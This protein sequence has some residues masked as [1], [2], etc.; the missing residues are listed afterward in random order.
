MT[1]RHAPASSRSPPGRWTGTTPAYL[2]WHL[3]DHLPEQYS[4]VRDPPRHEVARRRRVR[5]A[6]PGGRGRAR[7]GRGTPSA[8]SSPSRSRTR[9]PR[10]GGSAAG[11]PRRAATPSRPP[12]TCSAP[13][14]CVDAQRRA[15]PRSCRPPPSRSGR[16]AACTCSS[17]EP[18]DPRTRSRP[19]G[20]GTATEHLPALLAVEGVAGRLRVP[21]HARRSAR[22]TTRA[23]RFGVTAPWDPGQQPRHGRVPR[24]R[25]RRHGRPDSRPL[26]EARWADGIVTPRLAGPVP[27][28]RHL[29]GLARAAVGSSGARRP[30]LPLLADHPRWR[31]GAGARAGPLAA[32]PR[33][34]GAGARALRRPAARR[35]GHA[36]RPQRPDR[37][38]RLRRPPRPRPV[39]PAAHDPRPARRGLRGAPP[40]RADGPRAVR[41]RPAHGRRP[42]GRHVPRRRGERGVPRTWAGG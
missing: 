19:G 39:R 11:S 32:G 6:P 14:S 17:S 5:R 30:G 18:P 40:P 10:S 15:R 21:Q 28:P 37:R 20:G 33:P 27:Q 2:R 22:A 31:P 12:R 41:H 4:I 16:T 25:R 7:P 38:Q 13:S 9:S 23:P 3:L 26:V 8:T 42:E 36:A 35:R 29:R 1:D 24:R 34:R